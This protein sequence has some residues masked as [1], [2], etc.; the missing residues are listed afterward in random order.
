MTSVQSHLNLGRSFLQASNIAGANREAGL[1]LEADPRSGEACELRFDILC[2]ERKWKEALIWVDRWLGICPN[3]IGARR[4]EIEALHRNKN[5]KLARV[6]LDLFRSDFPFARDWHLSM[7]LAVDVCSGK[8]CKKE[9]FSAFRKT[10]TGNSHGD[11]VEGI[12]EYRKLRYSKAEKLFLKFHDKCPNDPEVLLYLSKT[13][14][15][16]GRFGKAREWTKRLKHVAPEKA[17]IANEIQLVSWAAYFPPFLLAHWLLRVWCLFY[18]RL[19]MIVFVPFF[20]FICLPTLIIASKYLDALIAAAIP[21]SYSKAIWYCLMVAWCICY[22]FTFL[23]RGIFWMHQP[24][25]MK[26]SSRY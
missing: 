24:K 12:V 3:D 1:A 19:H 2:A 10:A 6:K 13:A 22:S 5:Y 14:L 9:R 25:S 16:R 26:L 15:L 4:S 18:S 7:L 11:F 21:G 23:K 17:P 8:K 20:L